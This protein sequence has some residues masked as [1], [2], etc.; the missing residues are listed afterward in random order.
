MSLLAVDD[1]DLKGCS[2][3]S[4]QSTGNGTNLHTSWYLIKSSAASFSGSFPSFPS[5]NFLW[6]RIKDGLLRVACKG[7]RHT[8]P[9]LNI[10]RSREQAATTGNTLCFV[11]DLEKKKET[12]GAQWLRQKVTDGGEALNQD[13]RFYFDESTF[14]LITLL[15]GK[16]KSQVGRLS[17]SLCIFHKFI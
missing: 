2:E 13:I 7:N 4:Q 11:F 17:F 12:A 8:W 14:P 1:C 3:I 5:Y 6:R 10:L 15:I 9:S 16:D